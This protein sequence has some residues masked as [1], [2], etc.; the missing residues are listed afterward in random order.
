MTMLRVVLVSL[1]FAGGAASAAP[2]DL[3]GIRRAV[4]KE[5]AYESKAPRYCLLAIGPE[6]GFRVWLVLDGELLYVDRNGNGDLTEEGERLKP[7]GAR[8]SRL[9][10]REGPS[11]KEQVRRESCEY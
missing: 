8:A 10:T 5:P 4:D 2:P 7:N 1:A 9:V 6:A 11:G 3:T